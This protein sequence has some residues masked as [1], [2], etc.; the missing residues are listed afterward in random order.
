MC[1]NDRYVYTFRQFNGKVSYDIKILIHTDSAN[2]VL[3]HI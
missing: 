3:K 1:K 2:I